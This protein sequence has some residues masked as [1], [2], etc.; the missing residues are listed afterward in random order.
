MMMEKID[1]LMEQVNGNSEE[2]ADKK[3]IRTGGERQVKGRR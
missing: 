2:R 3:E 1:G